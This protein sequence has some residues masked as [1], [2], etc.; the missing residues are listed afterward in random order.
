MKPKTK[1]I[2]II[3]VAVVVVVAIVYLAFI[4]KRDAK[5]I[6]NKISVDDTTKAALLNKLSVI[7][8]TWDKAAIEAAAR[9]KG[10]DYQHQLVAEAAFSLYSD[11]ALT[12]EQLNA[13][14]SQL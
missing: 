1:K 10:R 13:I 5:S 7:E 3:A 14:V 11:G 8:S 12:Y 2:I 9:T 4:R 6:I